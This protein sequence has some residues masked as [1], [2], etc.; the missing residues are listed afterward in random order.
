MRA[1]EF[2]QTKVALPGGR[3]ITGIEQTLET[4]L[5]PA[6]QQLGGRT[7]SG[8]PGKIESLAPE[9]QKADRIIFFTTEGKSGPL[10]QAE[11][12][13]IQSST[14]FRAKTI[15]VYGGIK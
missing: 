6:A 5:Q 13:L 4:T 11:M 7:L 9:I 15:F 2:I 12:D 14:K 8:F 10:T 3:E 1:D